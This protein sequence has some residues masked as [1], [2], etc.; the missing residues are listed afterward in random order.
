[1]RFKGQRVRVTSHGPGPARGNRSVMHRG[2][3]EE[4]AAAEE[5][6]GNHPGPTPGE[7]A[8]AQRQTAGVAKSDG[9]GCERVCVPSVQRSGDLSGRPLSSS[10]GRFL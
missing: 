9:R 8:F 1:M 10:Q 2:G 4:D 7:P 5:G 6:C 3:K